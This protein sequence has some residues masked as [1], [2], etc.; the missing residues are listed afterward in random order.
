MS[1]KK[2]PSTKATEQKAKYAIDQHLWYIDRNRS[3]SGEVL[4]AKVIS[5]R[6]AKT[7]I[8]GDGF[9]SKVV[10]MDFYYDIQTPYG[11]YSQIHERLLFPNPTAVSLEFTRPFTHLLK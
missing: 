4:Q 5:V 6:S 1:T 3:R 9:V 11:Q 7:K 8:L 10:V 2:K